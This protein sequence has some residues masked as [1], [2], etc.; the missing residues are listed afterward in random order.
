MNRSEDFWIRLQDVFSPKDALAGQQGRDFYCEREHSPFNDMCIDFRKTASQTRPPI[1]FFTG[2]RGSGK[3]SMLLRLLEHF[4]DKFFVVYFDIEHNLESSKA[5]QIDLLYLLGA[6][7]FQTA[8]NEGINPKKDNL[9]ELAKSVYTITETKKDTG[10]ASFDILE[11]TKNLVCFGASMFGGSIGERLAGTLLKPVTFTSGVSEEIA[12]KREIEPRVQDITN[13]INL[14]I[15]DVQTLSKKD[16]FVVVDGLDKLQRKEQAELIFLKSRALLG[17]VCRI[18]YTAPMLIFN[19]LEFAQIEDTNK[20]YLLPNI[21]L[22]EKES[23]DKLYGKG[24]KFM[25]EVVRKR[26]A[27]LALQPCD[28]FEQ[29]VLDRLISKSGGITRFLIE[30][31]QSSLTAAELMKL[32]KVDVNATQ[33]AIDDRTAKLTG[34]LTSERLKELLHVRNNKLISGNQTSNELLHGL[35]IVA[36]RNGTTW[37][38][39][40]PLVWNELKGGTP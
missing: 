33:K 18:I 40:H 36:Y 39:A 3:S 2:H 14:I 35:L 38:D 23:D 26:L 20:S 27:S 10:K 34:R 37:F 24:Y 6:T 21:K 22:Y 5:N 16:L 30:L 8:T 9:D 31:V 25:R 15:A 28:V 32:R 4:K 17:P 12:R 13:N 19:S 1:A 29:N 11:L 7:I